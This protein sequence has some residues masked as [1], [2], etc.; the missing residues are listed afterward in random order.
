MENGAEKTCGRC[1][2]TISRHDDYEVE[3]SIECRGKGT[4][5]ENYLKGGGHTRYGCTHDPL[6]G[7]CAKALASIVSAEVGA[8][9]LSY[10]R[11]L[12]LED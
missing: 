7:E 1:K 6:C 3:V 12:R 5:S 10:I 11:R 2:R 4:Y 9:F 8:F